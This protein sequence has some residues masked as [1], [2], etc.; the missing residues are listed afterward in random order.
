MVR[1]D[2]EGLA[3]LHD[4]PK[5]RPVRRLTESEEAALAAIILKGPDSERD[6]TCAWTRADF[7]LVLPMVDATV[8]DLL[9]ARFAAT[10]AEDVHAI[11]VLDGA[12][13][14]DERALTVPV[15]VSLVTLLPLRT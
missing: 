7:T 11:M 5:G 2:A 4:R 15:N 13:S 3:S 14:H 8:M 10:L 1:Y 9:L 6:G 12:G